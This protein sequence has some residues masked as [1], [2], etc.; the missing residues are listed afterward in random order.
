MKIARRG[1]FATLLGSAVAVPVIANAKP[2]IETDNSYH[3]WWVSYETEDGTTI[4]DCPPATMMS[5]FNGFNTAEFNGP[6]SYVKLG[7]KII[8]RDPRTK[9]TLFLG[10]V[11]R[12][13]TYVGSFCRY[14]ATTELLS[15]P[16]YID[17]TNHESKEKIVRAVSE[18]IAKSLKTQRY[19]Q[20]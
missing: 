11:N 1:F 20:P 15:R 3:Q 7:K 10:V 4:I 9:E 17:I 14:H 8:I 19:P 2:T 18:Q 6:T 16:V 12:I 5:L 13:D